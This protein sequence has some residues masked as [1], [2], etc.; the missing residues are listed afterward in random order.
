MA[1]TLT[2]TEQPEVIDQ[3]EVLQGNEQPEQVEGDP[4]QP[5]KK[6]S[7][8]DF[9]AKIKAKYP[10]YKNV[11]DTELTKKI[12]AKYPVYSTQVD[13]PIEKKNQVGT[14]VSSNTS[15]SVGTQSAAT[16]IPQTVRQDNV[17]PFGENII[18]PPTP[19][20]YKPT[21]QDLAI[22]TVDRFQKTQQELTNSINDYSALTGKVLDPK[23]I[24]SSAD[25][26]SQFVQDLHSKLNE[27]K[28]AA[29]D[30]SA[31]INSGII[32]DPMSPT[33]GTT[34]EVHQELQDAAIRNVFQKAN[35]YTKLLKNH[36]VT[37]TI[38][39]DKQ[40]AV[41]KEVTISKIS[42]RLD[43]NGFDKIATLQDR[44]P[45][46]LPTLILNPYKA[47]GDL[48]DMVMGTEEKKD[49]LNSQK[50]QA[51]I[52]Y[53]EGNEQIAN[54]QIA[55]GILSN[56]QELI[57]SGKGI[58]KEVDNDA[59]YK[60]PS[61]VQQ[62]IVQEVSQRIA[63]ESG[64]LEGTNKEDGRT[65]EKVLGASVFDYARVMK[66]LGYWDNPKTMDV[67]R[68]LIYKR[69]LFKD[70]SYLGGTVDNFTAPF[71][72][73]GLSLGDISGF[74]N[75]QDIYT[76]KLRDEMF[77]KEF[78]PTETKDDFTLPVVGGVKV[79]KIV[80][81]TANLAGMVVI[82]AATEGLGTE[83]GLTANT[84][85]KL[86]AYTSFGLPSFDEN[87]KDSHNF[88][89]NPVAQNIYATMG[90]ILN[91]EGGRL[92]DLGK[93]S[94]VPGLKNTFS[95]IATGL[96]EKTLTEDAAKELLNKGE[97]TFVNYVE[98]YGANIANAGTAYAKN[99]SKGAAT[100][101]YFNATNSILKL[102][103]GDPNTKAE[104]LVPQAA[105][106]F[107]DG[108][109]GMSIMGAFGAAADMRAE[110]NTS[111]K[112]FLYDMSVNHDAAADI[113]KI[114]LENGTYTMDEYNQK[115][116]ILNTAIVA[117]NTL[118]A[119]Q[120]ERNTLLNEHQKS[121]YV[122]NKTAENFIR[123]KAENA[124]NEKLKEKYTAQANR[125]DQ[126]NKDVFDGLQ[127]SSTLEPLYDLFDAEKKYNEELSKF[128]NEETESDE[129]LLA[130]KD[131]L[132]KLQYKYLEENKLP[133]NV[134][135]EPT[136]NGTP[137]TENA[138]EV[139]D[140][141]KTSAFIGKDNNFLANK[142]PDFF[143][144]E[145]RVKYND[146]MKTEEGQTEADKMV[147][148]RKEELK[149]ATPET[150]IK[151]DTAPLIKE[152]RD[153]TG[154]TEDA[155]SDEDLLKNIAE[156]AQN[157]SGGEK[158][159]TGDQTQLYN[160]TV[161]QTGSKELVDAAIAKYPEKE[162]LKKAELPKEE[163][164]GVVVTPPDNFPEP[165]KLDGTRAVTVTPPDNFNEPITIG[166]NKPESKVDETAQQQI[167]Y[168]ELPQNVKDIVDKYGDANDKT[169]FN[170]K[171]EEAGYGSMHDMESF[172][173]ESG[174]TFYKLPKSDKNENT[175]DT[176]QSD[177][178]AKLA[179]HEKEVSDLENERDN[180][181]SE[182]QKP[183][184][185]EP[186]YITDT[187]LLK[188]KVSEKITDGEGNET[189]REVT[190]GKQQ[191]ELKKK[192]KVLEDLMDCLHKKA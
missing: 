78:S 46:T 134:K 63:E 13:L 9:A 147:S 123:N 65:L 60:Y 73:L 26:T 40:N 41:P 80:N 91:A 177:T 143:T 15:K 33:G 53:N 157:I 146:L 90:A 188:Q 164:S 105:H 118:D 137:V 168:D 155:V 30:R 159:K 89:E 48:Y 39:E 2:D 145:E 140:T 166:G 138:A 111:Y 19:D 79:R 110:K 192:Q 135:N 95:E 98:K 43:P 136:E 108:V 151:I 170:K 68:G 58:L 56:N 76:D 116:S 50:G 106:S 141:E 113:F 162:L 163:G 24:L 71:K 75:E 174:V 178:E 38:T 124:T 32:I 83:V 149:S 103:F 3:T 172:G 59:I 182:L 100:M 35:D 96:T 92:L 154:V 93:L 183:E 152:Y 109:T 176:S 77:P 169:E 72:N 156:Q 47:A 20:V 5:P 184:I 131:N 165:V 133:S 94:R 51:E 104:D 27:G 150:E 189:T 16:P 120:V 81:T 57:E 6:L 84:A 139:S 14:T 130:A 37:Q 186:E 126:Q 142:Q 66:E 128:T 70:A 190:R 86:G 161:E 69:W 114:G 29:Y 148:D 153:K 167:E 31:E 179:N 25:K 119:A 7:V 1:D 42:K 181:I 36:I 121:V 82:A 17:N 28:R 87:L 8:T 44:K 132:E 64:Q 10:Q 117:K 22:K 112:G 160:T 4:T 45:S 62:K 55:A 74:R 171:L 175:Q 21:P 49:L 11:D 122:A 185:K 107:L 115:M 52:A 34:G 127:F 191:S 88:L 101:A 158:N 67:A 102:G 85:Q 97:K 173:E 12:I 23:D 61:L 54:N 18:N 129:G 99:V 180:K 125:L 144:P 187:D